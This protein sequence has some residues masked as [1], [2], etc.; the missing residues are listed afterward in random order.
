MG[1]KKGGLHIDRLLSNVAIQILQNSNEFIFNK[2]F[3]VLPVD[4]KSDL[5][6][7]YTQDD[8]NTDELQLNN[9]SEETAGSAYTLSDEPY[10]CKVFG[11]HRDVGEQ[12]V[13]DVEMD[14]DLFKDATAFVTRK[15]LLGQEKRW[16]EKYL[17]S[18]TW[19]Y[20]RVGGTDFDK[21]DEVTSSPIKYFKAE[22]AD[23]LEKTGMMP[24]RFVI[25]FKAFNEL[26]EHPDIVDRVKFTSLDSVNAAI[27]ANLIGVE[28]VLV[29]KSI[30]ATGKGATKTTSFNFGN[31]GLLCYAANAPGKANPSAGYTFSWKYAP[32]SPIVIKRFF[33]NE[34]D[35]TR[36]EAKTA[37]DMKATAT[38]LGRLYTNM[39]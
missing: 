23:M 14:F 18:G 20:T 38:S 22:I 33:I 26:T 28:Q 30:I 17:A 29:A 1:V 19:D 2:V 27:L 7:V 3:P 39:V 8:W 31:N 35:T 21:V 13:N 6:P 25:G 32:V 37:F 36:I 10:I 4:R 9:D 16:V 24:N 15:V 5:Y 12:L 11:I 34:K